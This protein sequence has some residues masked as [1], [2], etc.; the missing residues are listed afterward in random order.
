[1]KII[2]YLENDVRRMGV[3]LD[4]GVCPLA[5][6]D[7][8]YAQPEAALS[9]AA[10]D[11]RLKGDQLTLVPP[12]LPTARI[13]CVGINYK[14]HAA[15]SK[16]ATGISEPASPMI[17]GRWAS[18]LVLDGT[19]VPVPPNEPGLDWE[20]ELAVIIGKKILGATRDTAMDA[21]LGYAAF[22]DISARK[23][24]T[25]TP[26]FTLG[27]N[28]D[29]SG[30]ISDAIVTKDEIDPTNL[31]VQALVNGQI[32]QDANTRDMIHDIERI[33]CS[34]TETVTLLPGDVIATG[35]PGGVGI[36][37]T[38]PVFLVPGDRVEVRV[39]GI[40]SVSNPIVAR[41]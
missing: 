13:F 7:A 10:S 38:P 6:M 28:A 26:Q 3:R 21:V 17:F 40:G 39:E 35:T 4:D 15:E 14:E 8:F 9:V 33:I 22:N 31:R 20:V 11:E 12:V 5:T 29:N 1:M 34:I 19:P 18:T 30:P 32:M 41:A 25:E 37:R 27:K 24:Q 16:A 23:K 2:A 36:G